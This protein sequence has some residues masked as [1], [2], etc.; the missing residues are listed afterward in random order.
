MIRVYHVSTVITAYCD[1][2]SRN[3]P[4]LSAVGVVLSDKKGT[5]VE[6]GAVFSEK[7]TNNEAEYAALILTMEMA[8]TLGA[9]EILIHSD[10]ELVVKQMNAEYQCKSETLFP[11]FCRASKLAG[12]F[13]SFKIK[14][15]RRTENCRADRLANEAMDRYENHKKSL[16]T[17]GNSATK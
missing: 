9:T 11:L 2:G 12:K 13:S 1:G 3:N 4:G 7:A 8:L 14:H 16:T 5:L 6:L 15:V 10:S 17:D